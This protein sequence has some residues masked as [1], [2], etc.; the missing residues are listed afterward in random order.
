M[1]VSEDYKYIV[2]RFDTKDPAC[3][4]RVMYNIDVNNQVIGLYDDGIY[5]TFDRVLE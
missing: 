5:T 2:D 1:W 4:I 3:N